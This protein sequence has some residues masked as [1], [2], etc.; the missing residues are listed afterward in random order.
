MIT[1]TWDWFS[2]IAGIVVTITVGFWGL[3]GLAFK[4]WKA[5]KKR[6]AEMTELFKSWPKKSK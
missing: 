5:N 1:I 4:Q 2:F 6:E 3:L